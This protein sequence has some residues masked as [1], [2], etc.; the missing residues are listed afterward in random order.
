MGRNSH[1][2]E[3]KEKKDL[4]SSGWVW[5]VCVLVSAGIGALTY[6]YVRDTFPGV[7][8]VAGATFFLLVVL[9][10]F[11]PRIYFTGPSFLAIKNKIVRYITECNE[12]NQHIQD[13][14][15]SFLNVKKTDYGEASFT[16]ISRYNY[17]KRMVQSA[18]YSSNVYDCSRQ[19]CDSARKQPFK[20]ICKYFNIK[21]N[22]ESL[23][24]F[25][26]VLNNF[27]AAEEGKYLLIRKKKGILKK[28]DKK[29][30]WLIRAIAPKSLERELGFKEF[31]F[32]ELYFPTYSFR[33]ISPG[34]NSGTRFDIEMDIKMMNRFIH[35]LAE[36]VKFSKSVEGQ[37]RLM[38]PKLRHMIIERDDYTCQLCGNS[39]DREPNLLLEVDHIIPVSKGGITSEENLQTLCWKC[40]R[41]KGARIA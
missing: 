26:E 35:Y 27:S 29:I 39:T 5:F 11:I 2:V 22:E 8:F 25:E 6:H 1:I 7:A 30:P 16:N 23:A 41:R 18:R 31:K 40:N 38:T 36:S 12:L 32:D 24:G 4:F 15:D 9:I 34:G 10:S 13:L 33:Y 17:K 28:I 3:F 19:V 20:Y 37:R 14:R 21:A